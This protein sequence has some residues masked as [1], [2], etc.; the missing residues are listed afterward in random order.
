M[1]VKKL[2][3]ILLLL[4]FLPAGHSESYA[5]N[6]ITDTEIIIGQSCA[7]TGPAQAIGISMKE[8]LTAY[9]EKI[10]QAGGIK[11][12]TIRLISLDDGYEPEKAITNTRQL[13]G[14][15]KVFLTIGYVGTPTSKAVFPILDELNIP[16]FAP[17]T[18]A[19]FLRNPLKKN[20]INIRASYYQEMEKLAQY[21]V[22]ILHKTKIACFFQNDDYGQAGLLGIQLALKKRSL[23]L[24]ATGT[25]E[26][27]SM[28]VKSGFLKIRKADP[29]AV[30]MV[31]AY[32]PCA[33][34][35]KIAKAH[36]LEDTLFCNISFVGTQALI[37]ELGEQGNGTI[38]S[39]VVQYP[40]D[41]SIPVV[42]E[43]IKDM[44][45]FIPEA[46]INFISFEG[47][48]T[49]KFFCTALAKT[50]TT[51][52]RSNLIAAIEAMGTIDLDGIKLTF[53]KDDHQGMDDVFL[54][55]IKDGKTQ[56][57]E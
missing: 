28:A 48:I 1:F 30:V 21:L 55:V 10:N 40:W 33:E 23:E 49:A 39:Q 14:N 3:A 36:G 25:Y 8:G 24:M 54:T 47:Y 53:G 16:F 11:G 2:S 5:E 56:P 38:I 51:L 41:E 43:F 4:F 42:K 46:K 19:E 45:Q 27:N 31:G 17:F 50:D 32:Q 57:I 26:R 29:E 20:V 15:D 35:I 37:N 6:G 12:R 44:A 34:F 18:G 52:T 22:D 13:I 7:L 9:F